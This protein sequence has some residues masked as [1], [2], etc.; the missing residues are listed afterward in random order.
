M[1]GGFV[2]SS[3]SSMEEDPLSMS[4]SSTTARKTPPPSYDETQTLILKSEKKSSS[5]HQTGQ[6]KYNRRNNPDLEK[7]RIH[8][9]DHPG[10]LP[11]FRASKFL[12]SPWET[13]QLSNNFKKTME[14]RLSR[15]ACLVAKQKV[16]FNHQ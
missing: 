5:H 7:R 11:P 15:Q 16:R 12:L 3:S 14:C 6:V 9:C 4:T 1:S 10:K 8:F 13:P 2:C